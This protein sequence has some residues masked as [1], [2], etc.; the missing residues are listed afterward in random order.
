MFEDIITYIMA[1]ALRHK[2][3]MAARYKRRSLINQQHNTAYM[4]WVV[5]D[6][7]F[8]Q[9]LIDKD[10]FTL[11]VNCD[12]LAFP[13]GGYTVL[14]AQRDAFQVAC[15]VLAK[16]DQDPEWRPYLSVYDYS[17]L[18]VSEFTADKSAGQRL[19]LELVIPDPVNLCTLDD[20]FTDE[21][22]PEPT[23]ADIDLAEQCDPSEGTLDLKPVRLRQ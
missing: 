9:K 3:V 1:T 7:P 4:Q 10:I 5:E 12:I 21:P 23:D 15:E 17:L 20:N 19:T 13:K 2:A 11:T 22:T 18:A 8:A 6:D 16:I 14:D